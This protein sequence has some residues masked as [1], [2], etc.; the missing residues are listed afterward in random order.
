MIRKNILKDGSCTYTAQL[1]IKRGGKIVFSEAKNFERES[2]AKNWLAR[3]RH[4]MSQPGAIEKAQAPQGTLSAA[5]DLYT[6][7]VSAI[8]RT[9]AQVL[10]SLKDYP[11]SE[12]NISAIR[13]HHVVELARQLSDGSRQPQTVQNYLS[14][15]G[16]VF[17]V[18]TSAYG[19]EV[20]R[21]AI[22]DAL[23][24]TRR[25]G[26]TRKSAQRDRRPSV[27][28][29]NR[30]MQHFDEIRRKRPSSN[31][32]CA[33]TAFALFSTRRQE[34]IVRLKWTDLEAD[35]TRV[36]VR[37]MKHPGQKIGNHVLVELP[38]EAVQIVKSMPRSD[39]RIF[40]FMSDAV[41]AAFAR[42]CQFLDIKDLRFHDL[43][44]EGISRMF[45]MGFTI[46]QAASVSGHRSWNSLKRY[47]H[48]RDS[49]DK[50]AGW[51]WLDRIAPRD[52][53]GG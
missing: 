7:D 22:S 46:P 2:I 19:F 33:I 35:F 30:I 36:V 6:S 14:H 32:M 24:T 1:R 48:L 31:P 4:E 25:L 8:G 39:E 53:A 21:H 5:I 10:R 50:W 47:S 18:A 34:E 42:A 41:S 49:G 17:S 52:E 26:I 15:I 9:K 23:E 16:G 3:R 12:M 44:H 45:E 37:D 28:E 20:D 38:P 51:E 29:M 43:R 27:G 40:P 11:I 13:A